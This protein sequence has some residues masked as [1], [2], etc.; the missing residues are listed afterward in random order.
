MYSKCTRELAAFILLI[1][2]CVYGYISNG[3]V[4]VVGIS[5]GY[6]AVIEV[7]NVFCWAIIP[8]KPKRRY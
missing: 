5:A 3:V 2:L 4:G 1:A 8:K 7:W 6:L